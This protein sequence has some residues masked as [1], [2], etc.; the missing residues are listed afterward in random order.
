[1]VLDEDGDQR[2]PEGRLPSGDE[3]LAEAPAD[4]LHRQSLELWPQ[5]VHDLI[6]VDGQLEGLTLDHR[7]T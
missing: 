3:L 1:M 4:L 7:G 2:I 6:R 5:R